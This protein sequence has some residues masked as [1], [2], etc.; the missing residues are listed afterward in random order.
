MTL[1]SAKRLNDRCHDIG[2]KI[3]STRINARRSSGPRSPEGKT[4]AARNA[5]RHG[6]AIPVSTL[7]D[8]RSEIATLAQVIAKA[9][10]KTTA[11]ELS[12]QAAEA[13]MEILRIRKVRS[14]LLSRAIPHEELSKELASLERYE[15]RAYSKRKRALR[16]LE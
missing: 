16:E 3:S 1:S 15:R 2:Q 9:A 6:L 14:S 7:A 10:G 13:Q 4:R 5:L 8:L 11:T 12:L